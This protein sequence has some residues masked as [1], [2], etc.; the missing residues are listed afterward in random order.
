MSFSPLDLEH[1]RFTLTFPEMDEVLKLVLP[2]ENDLERFL[3]V[4]AVNGL[5]TG[6]MVRYGILRQAPLDPEAHPNVW[7][8]VETDLFIR[9]LDSRYV[10]EMFRR[11]DGALATYQDIREKLHGTPINMLMPVSWLMKLGWG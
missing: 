9:I 8:L 5:M 6:S 11:S 10:Q 2:P 7:E 4:A 1:R 3:V